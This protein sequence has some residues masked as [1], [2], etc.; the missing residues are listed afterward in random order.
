MD[1]APV[2][3][4]ELASA[5]KAFSVGLLSA[6]HMFVGGPMGRLM[7][8]TEITDDINTF[9]ARGQ[10]NVKSPVT[11]GTLQRLFVHGEK[12]YEAGLLDNIALFSEIVRLIRALPESILSFHHPLPSD[13]F[14]AA[15]KVIARARREFSHL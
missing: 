13:E 5:V 3:E 6:Q 1:T 10:Y 8:W 14:V 2:T 7:V 9:I 12:I 4:E 15:G 11:W